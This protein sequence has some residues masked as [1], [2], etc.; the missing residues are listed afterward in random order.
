VDPGV[1]GGAVIAILLVGVPAPATPS[2]AAFDTPVGPWARLAELQTLLAREER[3]FEL[4]RWSWTIGYGMLS[5]VNLYF[6]P[7]APREDRIDLYVG[8]G[9]SALALAPLLLWSQPEYRPTDA[10]CSASPLACAE[11]TWRRVATFQRES[12][13]LMVHVINFAY[14]A[15]VGALLGFGYGH[16]RAAALNFGVGSALG[17]VQILTQPTRAIRFGH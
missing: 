15:A 6:V 1:I 16:W 13:G 14:N 10:A 5:A 3:N 2:A 7:T 12:Q 9:A 8:A 4:W 11:N 17:E